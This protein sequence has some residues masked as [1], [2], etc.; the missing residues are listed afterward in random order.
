MGWRMRA[1]AWS[2]MPAAGGGLSLPFDLLL[3]LFS[4]RSP[5]LVVVSL[6]LD[7][8]SARRWAKDFRRGWEGALLSL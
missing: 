7:L 4:S 5:L 8:S 6:H 1:Q 2:D 3:F